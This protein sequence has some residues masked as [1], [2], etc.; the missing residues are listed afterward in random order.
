MNGV[1]VA[2]QTRMTSCYLAIVNSRYL[3][4]NLRMLYLMFLKVKMANIVG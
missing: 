1:G 2:G 3:G 4:G